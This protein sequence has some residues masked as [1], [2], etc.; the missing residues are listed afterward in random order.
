MIMAGKTRPVLLKQILDKLDE[1][2]YM[3][4]PQLS[5][6]KR[7]CIR[8]LVNEKLNEKNVVVEK[9]KEIERLNNMLHDSFQGHLLNE[10]QKRD[11]EIKSLK[12]Q[13]ER[14]T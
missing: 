13:V 4:N 2:E 11:E 12:K 6:T 5:K 7:D 14:L 9:D 8:E 10:L 1:I 3:D